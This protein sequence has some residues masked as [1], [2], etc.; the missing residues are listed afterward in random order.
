MRAVATHIIGKLDHGHIVTDTLCHLMKHAQDDWGN[1]EAPLSPIRAEAG[2]ALKDTASPEVWM[3]M[4]DAFFVNPRNVLAGFMIDWITHLT[5]QLDGVH[6]A[7]AGAWW[8]N[9]G[10][11]RWFRALSEISEEQLQQMIS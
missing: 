8:G 9:E 4:V 11:R 7:Y 2:E 10:N 6:T 1:D 5:D 3:V